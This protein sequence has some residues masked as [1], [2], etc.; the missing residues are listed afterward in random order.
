L[1]VSWTDGWF[2]GQTELAL[3]ENRATL[4]FKGEFTL[5]AIDNNLFSR[6]SL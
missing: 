2:R 3:W 5:A 4:R 1:V 6:P